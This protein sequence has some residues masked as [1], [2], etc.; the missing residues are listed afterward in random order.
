VEEDS[1]PPSLP[2]TPK[3]RNEYYSLSEPASGL[4]PARG[5][6]TPGQEQE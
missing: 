5:P 2:P 1:P 6:G 3:R 4:G